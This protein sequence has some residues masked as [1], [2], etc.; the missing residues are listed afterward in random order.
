MNNKL[1]KLIKQQTSVAHQQAHALIKDNKQRHA[2]F[3][4]ELHQLKT[5]KKQDKTHNF[6]ELKLLYTTKELIEKFNKQDKM[7]IPLK[8]LEKIIKCNKKIHINT[9]LIEF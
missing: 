9:A 4:A 7:Y 8:I 5:I 1:H 2:E 6:S 3:H